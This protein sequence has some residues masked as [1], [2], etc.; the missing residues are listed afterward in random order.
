MTDDG[1]FQRR[2]QS[3]HT[4]Q[5]T[6]DGGT[7]RCYYPLIVTILSAPNNFVD[8]LACR[9]TW[10]RYRSNFDGR[11]LFRFVVAETNDSYLDAKINLEQRYNVF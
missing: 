5:P 1:T 6:N 2:N 4:C 11:M 10:F 8:R 9:D 3:A 7:D